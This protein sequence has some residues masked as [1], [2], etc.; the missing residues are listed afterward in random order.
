M[1]LV[2]SKF[3]VRFDTKSRK[4]RHICITWVIVEIDVKNQLDSSATLA[5]ILKSLTRP[6]GWNIGKDWP[7]YTMVRVQIDA[8]SLDNGLIL[9]HKVEI[10]HILQNRYFGYRWVP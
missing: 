2:S 4:K 9:S 1:P 3:E 7:V 6:N 10:M 5:K 8:I